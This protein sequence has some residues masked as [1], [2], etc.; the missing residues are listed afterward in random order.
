MLSSLRSRPE[1]LVF[2]E[3]SPSYYPR[4]GFRPA[5]TAGFVKPS[6]RIPDVALQVAQLGEESSQLTGRLVYPDPFWHTDS[7]GLR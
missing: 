5:T 2:L 3:G 1:Q 6:D 4:F 7:V